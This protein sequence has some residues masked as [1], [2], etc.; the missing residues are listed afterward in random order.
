MAKMDVINDFKYLNVTA[1]IGHN[2][3]SLKDAVTLSS[4]A[5][6]AITGSKKR[7]TPGSIR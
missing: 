4:K 6:S 7:S 2:G 5:C 3:V 1:S